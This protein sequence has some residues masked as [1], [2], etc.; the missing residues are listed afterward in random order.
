M[1]PPD[2]ANIPNVVDRVEAAIGAEGSQRTDLCTALLHEGSK[3]FL[4]PTVFYA[5]ALWGIGNRAG[6]YTHPA[7]P[8]LGQVYE[9]VQPA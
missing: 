9:T 3:L 5:S 6:D 7:V 2:R 4:M 8:T 1:G